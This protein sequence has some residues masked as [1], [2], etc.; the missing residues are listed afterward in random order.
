MYTCSM[1]SIIAA[2]ILSTVTVA[3]AAP[4]R[5]VAQTGW[6]S[7]ERVVLLSDPCDATTQRAQHITRSNRV[8]SGCWHATPVGVT[9]E[10]NTGPAEHIDY[11]NLYRPGEH[12]WIQMSYR[13]L[14]DRTRLLRFMN[15]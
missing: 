14:Y 7:P 8:R 10:W 2:L 4:D 9:I 13:T 5:L 11:L 15:Q 12:H 3:Q 6:N 1:K